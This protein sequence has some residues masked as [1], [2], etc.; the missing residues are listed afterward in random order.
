MALLDLSSF[1]QLFQ[2]GENFEI[3]EEQYEEK[4]KKKLPQTNYLKKRSPVA[5]KAY[6]QGLGFHKKMKTKGRNHVFY[7][8]GQNDVTVMILVLSV[9]LSACVSQT[10][11]IK[12]Q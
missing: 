6:S 9:S 8:E 5:R 11:S 3:T 7:G 12:A 2:K 1:E 10:I 4:V